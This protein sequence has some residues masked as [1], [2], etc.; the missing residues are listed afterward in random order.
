MTFLGH[1]VL[2][3]QATKDAALAAL[4]A[5]LAA[6]TAEALEVAVKLL[7]TVGQNLQVWTHSLLMCNA[8]SVYSLACVYDS[9]LGVCSCS[10][11]CVCMWCFV[12]TMSRCIAAADSMMPSSVHGSD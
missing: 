3:G 12:V 10:A 6:P 11:Y 7:D 2:Q 9:M 8:A 5:L 1:L 4:D